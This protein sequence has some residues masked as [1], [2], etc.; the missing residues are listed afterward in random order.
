M[1]G[2]VGGGSV[3]NVPN[4]LVIKNSIEFQYYFLGNEIKNKF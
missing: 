4:K 1:R 3:G 2:T